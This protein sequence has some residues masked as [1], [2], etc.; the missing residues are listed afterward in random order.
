MYTAF[1][2]KD[3]RPDWL[4]AQLMQNDFSPFSQQSATLTKNIKYPRLKYCSK[5]V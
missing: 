1:D 2:N 4:H 5:Q 3:F